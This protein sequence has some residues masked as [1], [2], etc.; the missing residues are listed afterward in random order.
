MQVGRYF[1]WSHGAKGYDL[2]KV[3]AKEAS[4]NSVIAFVKSLPLAKNLSFPD[5]NVSVSPTTT[6]GEQKTNVVLSSTAPADFS[7][8]GQEF[9][10]ETNSGSAAAKAKYKDKTVQI[11][12]RVEVSSGSSLM[13]SAGTHSIFAYYDP[14]QSAVFS[15]LERDERVVIKCMVEA[16]YSI[17][18]N[19][20]VLVENKGVISPT[21]TPD[22]TF[23]ADEYWNAVASYDIPVET[24]MKKQDELKGKII[25][26]TGKVKDLAG[27]KHYL[28]AGDDDEFPCY[29]DDENK[30][31]FSSL[32]EGQSVTV[33]AVGGTSLSHCLVVSN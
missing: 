16:E 26:I 27:T 13:M 24:K 30:P 29:P 7:L 4:L 14:A 9:Y 31:S 20:C 33:L 28:A 22:V 15:E 11:S 6:N 25:K 3:K 12:S 18:L 1:L 23:T 17:K 32:T 19:D 8:T 10:D 2:E 5:A 21:D